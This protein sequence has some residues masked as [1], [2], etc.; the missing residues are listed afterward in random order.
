MKQIK[1]LQKG[2]TL[3]EVIVAMSIFSIGTAAVTM[4]FAAAVKY[5]S[6]NQRRDEELAFQQAA[7]ENVSTT[8]IELHDGLDNMTIAFN[9]GSN[10][11]KFVKPDGTTY[12]AYDD[13]SMIR[14]TRS[15]K[16]SDKFEFTLK[17]IVKG[18][19]N[20]PTVVSNPADHTYKI[21][22]TNP[23]DKNIDVQLKISRGSFYEG[24]YGGGYTHPS[25]VFAR[26][27]AGTSATGVNIGGGSTS[28]PSG[29]EVG[30]YNSD[31]TAE[32]SSITVNIFMD[33]SFKSTLAISNANINS[34]PNGECNIT[35]NAAGV[36]TAT[37]S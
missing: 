17:D 26:S 16:N 36:A 35:V 30:Y 34:A 1:K 7:V 9:N 37:F 4:A 6:L 29:F 31:I 21:K 23:T 24:S 25:H 10:P 28:L 33:G 20:S 2:M 32:S 8:G 3:L 11:I 13:V 14:A 12:E 18:A 15:G 5:N 19:V 27:A 22:F